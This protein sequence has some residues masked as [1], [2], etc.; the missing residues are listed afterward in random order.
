MLNGRLAA[1]FQRLKAFSLILT[2]IV[3]LEV[4][5]KVGQVLDILEKDTRPS[6]AVQWLLALIGIGFAAWLFLRK[7]GG[8]GS[9]GQ[10]NTPAPRLNP[11]TTD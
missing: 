2:V 10:T 7:R 4:K 9:S 11:P 1:I 3:S 6:H 8:G 5:L